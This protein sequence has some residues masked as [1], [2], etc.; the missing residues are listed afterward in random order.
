M[1]I[2]AFQYVE[3]QSPDYAGKKFA[4]ISSEKVDTG[5]GALKASM[6]SLPSALLAIFGTPALFYLTGAPTYD[7]ETGEVTSPLG[8]VVGATVYPE[9]YTLQDRAA[10]KE[11]LKGDIRLY[12]PG[13]AFGYA[14]TALLILQVRDTG[15]TASFVNG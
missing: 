8:S 9:A 12:V 4:I 3:I 13:K 2:S 7:P 14:T 6:M 1:D 11:I 5:E 15:S 10:I